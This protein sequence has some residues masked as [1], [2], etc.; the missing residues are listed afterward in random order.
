MAKC[1]FTFTVVLGES[2]KECEIKSRTDVFSTNMIEIHDYIL[3]L[4]GFMINSNT[5]RVFSNEA[6]TKLI[7]KLTSLT[8]PTKKTSKKR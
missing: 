3:R 2:E 1:Y 6:F 8:L 5:G 7:V 4:G